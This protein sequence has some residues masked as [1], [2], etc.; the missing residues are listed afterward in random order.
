MKPISR[1]P[2]KLWKNPVRKGQFLHTSIDYLANFVRLLE[3]M[4][5]EIARSANDPDK[6]DQH[7]FIASVL[8]DETI[9]LF[10]K[11]QIHMPVTNINSEDPLDYINELIYYI[12][13]I[14]KKANNIKSPQLMPVSSRKLADTLEQVEQRVNSVLEADAKKSKSVAQNNDIGDL[15]HLFHSL[16]V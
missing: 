9:E 10:A 1:H 14:I 8:K 3:N 5:R 2:V 16:K 4:K 7:S 13:D 15:S 12:K 6:Y 11:N